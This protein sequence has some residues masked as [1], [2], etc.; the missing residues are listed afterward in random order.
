MIRTFTIE[1]TNGYNE[2]PTTL[3]VEID[4]SRYGLTMEFEGMTIDLS[5]EA[6]AD[7]KAALQQVDI[8]IT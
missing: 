8:S 4:D 3:K 6:A 7:L 2:A 1:V 5:N